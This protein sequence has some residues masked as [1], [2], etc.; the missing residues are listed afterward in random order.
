MEGK[1]KFFNHNRGYGF[2]IAEG[3]REIFAHATDCKE[4]L[5]MDDMV[6]FEEI[7]NIDSKTQKRK[8]TKAI[9]IKKI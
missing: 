9:N 1:I 6:V 8:G 2:I 4:Q 5:G 7:D 3:G